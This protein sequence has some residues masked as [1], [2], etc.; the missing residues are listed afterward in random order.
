[1]TRQN[2]SLRLEPL[3]PRHA[4]ATLVS[5]TTV[6]YQDA[7]GDNVTVVLS[8]PVLTPGNVNTVFHFD[9]GD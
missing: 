5:P 4:P 6:T 3:E 9:T 1:M 7:D 8:R 2:L